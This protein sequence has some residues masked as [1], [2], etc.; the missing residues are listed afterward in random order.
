MS[1]FGFNFNKAGKGI[2]KGE[3]ERN[4]VF[5]FFESLKRNFWNLMKAN[6]CWFVSAIP[7]FILL[8]L[9]FSIF[10]YPHLEGTILELA[11]SAAV[12][13][14]DQTVSTYYSQFMILFIML[15]TVVFKSGPASAAF[16]YLSK[17]MA[18]EEH[19]WVFSDFFKQF[20]ENFLKS[21]IVLVIDLAAIF[22]FFNA[23]AVYLSLYKN[24][25]NMIY[26][27]LLSLMAIVVV[28]Y[29]FMHGYVYQMIATFDNKLRILYKNAFILAFAKFPQNFLL[30]FVPLVITYFVFT[31]T[32]PALSAILFIGIW[33]AAMSYPMEF[34][35]ARTIKKLTQASCDD[36]KDD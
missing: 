33:P 15:V 16:S 2:E 9:F 14:L 3:T 28:F 12:Q 24:T 19:V 7:V 8:G 11:K 18:N 22:I 17:C 10:V 21:I 20:K 23:F 32:A 29:T 30:I 26:F 35:A 31:T 13:E 36:G 1:I 4:L 6:F 25:H 27:V 34:Y 5:D